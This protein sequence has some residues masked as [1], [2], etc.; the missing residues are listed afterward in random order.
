MNIVPM[1]ERQD[2]TNQFTLT[3]EQLA[4]IFVDY[5]LKFIRIYTKKFKDGQLIAEIEV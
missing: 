5:G 1:E 4:P 2:L 3:N